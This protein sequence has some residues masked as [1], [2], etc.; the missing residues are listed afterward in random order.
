[1]DEIE[2]I[3]WSNGK[4]DEDEDPDV[5]YEVTAPGNP[6][7]PHHRDYCPGCVSCC[8]EDDIIVSERLMG[9]GDE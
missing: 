2:M 8:I 6:N 7:H 1:M 5:M 4:S 9:T 3:E